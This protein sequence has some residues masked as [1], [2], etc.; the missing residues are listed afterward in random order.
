ML[1]NDRFK[2]DVVLVTGTASGI[3][4]ATAVRFAREGAHVCC[5]DINTAENAE[6][7]K[8]ITSAGGQ[9][10]AITCDVRDPR[11]CKDAAATAIATYQKLTVL[12]NVAGI[13]TSKNCADE[14]VES[15]QDILATNVSG[16]FYLSQAALPQLLQHRGNIVN[17][18]STAGLVGHAYMTSYCAS[19]HAII[20]LTRS[21]AVEFARKGVRVNAVCPGGVNTNISRGQQPMPAGA[22]IDL[23]SRLQVNRDIAEPEDM[24]NVICFAASREAAFMTGSILSADGGSVAA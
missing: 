9:A 6:T 18:A 1:M 17:V 24:A 2:G 14:T 10:I 13:W 20:G 5:I 16:P 8:K 4:R 19:K 22:D 23:V 15:W 21:M 11:Q 12:C 7:V 3:G